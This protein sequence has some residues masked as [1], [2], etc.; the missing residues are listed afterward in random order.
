[1]YA[2]GVYPEITLAEARQ[3]RDEARRKVLDGV[4]PVK[5]RQV[6]A[7]S[8]VENTFRKLSIEWHEFKKSRWSAGYA[9]DILE[10]FKMDIYP[11]IGDL[12]VDSIEPIYALKALSAIE[13]RGAT[14]KASK[15]R[16]WQVKYLSMQ[17]QRVERSITPSQN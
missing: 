1:M 7:V 17:L 3:K 8:D 9:S 13:Q 15:V 5:A 12:P 11:V 14:E 4:D 6:K 10:A 16:R 2:I